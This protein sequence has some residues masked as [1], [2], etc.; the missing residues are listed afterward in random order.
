TEARENRVHLLLKCVGLTGELGPVTSNLLEF[1][2]IRL[3]PYECEAVEVLKESRDRI[4]HRRGQRQRAPD[5]RP[6]QGAPGFDLLRAIWRGAGQNCSRPRSL[7]LL[8]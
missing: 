6:R 3:H 4:A 5:A 8:R 7:C 1:T 2:P